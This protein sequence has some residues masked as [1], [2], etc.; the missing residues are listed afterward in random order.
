[1]FDHF[2]PC[3]CFHLIVLFCVVVVVVVFKVEIS[4]GTLIPFFRP[5]SGHVG[6][7]S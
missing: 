2:I 4:S 7:A 3:L 1:M 6:S 5:G